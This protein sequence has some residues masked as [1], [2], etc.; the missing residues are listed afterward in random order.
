MKSEANTGRVE[1]GEASDARGRA[2]AVRVPASTS[3]LGA[4]FDCFGLALR[5]Y[6]NVRATVMHGES[7]PCRVRS[8]GENEKENA[9]SRTTD[10]LIFRAM[11]FAAEREGLSLPPVRLAVHNQVPLGR[12]L[13]SS[14][15]AIVAGLKLCSLLCEKEITDAAVLRYA[16]EMEGHPDNIGAALYGGLIVNCVRPDG[17]VLAIKR[18]W[19]PDV[20]V[21]VVSPDAH[22]KT[23]QARSTLPPMV[24]RSDAVYNLQRTAL[25]GAA[26]E[27]GTYEMLWEAMQD[28]L[29]Q[30][31]RQSFV[32]GLAAALATPQ[33]QG[34]LGLAMSGS[35]PSIIA[36]ATG[37]FT[38]I[39]HTIAASFER[40]GTRA[41]V[42]LLEVDD[43][44]LRIERLRRRAVA[45][46]S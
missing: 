2:F 25:F 41:T 5:L 18:R 22:L 38:E 33:Q 16:L 13:G 15:A 43:E 27:A 46:K 28:R 29:H 37:R 20:K 42:R 45:V 12:G 14:A 9:L 26:L 24:A 36:L 4:G 40:H 44:G 17:S 32:P 39:G 8:L 19:P 11:R 35:G 10:N 21:I 31:H 6:L 23:A 1:N 34:L 30:A 7:E 3:N